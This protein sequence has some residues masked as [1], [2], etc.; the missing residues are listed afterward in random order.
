MILSSEGDNNLYHLK[1][2]FRT[3]T[4]MTSQFHCTCREPGHYVCRMIDRLHRNGRS[5]KESAPPVINDFS[6]FLVYLFDN[7]SY[8]KY[9]ERY[10]IYVISVVEVAVC[11]RLS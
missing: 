6:I 8:E 1:D 4:L 5:Q 7:K 9:N 10:C 3:V 11:K 2:T